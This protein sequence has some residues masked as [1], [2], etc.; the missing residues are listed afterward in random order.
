M[1]KDG[2]PNWFDATYYSSKYEDLKSAFN[3]NE[4]AL[5]N[6]C[7]Q[8]GFSEARLVTPVLDVAKYREAYPDLDKAFGNNWQLYIRHYFEY[9][10]NE[11]RENFTDFDANAYLELHADVRNVAGADLGLA[12]KHYLEHGISE[13]RS[14]DLPE[15]EVDYEESDYDDESS[16][17]GSSDDD[18]TDET[19]TGDK[20]V[21]FEDG[22]YIIETY[23]RDLLTSSKFYDEN[24]ILLGQATHTYDTNGTLVS[25]QDKDANGNVK[26]NTTKMVVQ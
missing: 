9:G 1:R 18:T 15:P 4:K 2:V 23:V 13:G 26:S 6:H 8:Y 14:Y 24:N 16:D 17:S 22:S 19:F 3:T 20:R 7:L 10:I 12:T 11:G 25:S 21:E 5:Y